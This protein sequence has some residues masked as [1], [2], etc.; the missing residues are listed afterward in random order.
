[1]KVRAF[2]GRPVATDPLSQ[3]CISQI[4]EWIREC[5][6]FHSD[7]PKAQKCRLPSRVLD[8]QKN[9]LTGDLKL[10]INMTSS[11]DNWIALS[12]CWAQ[13]EHRF[14][15]TTSNEGGLAERIPSSLLPSTI[16]DAVLVTRKTGIQYLGVDTLCILQD[17]T[18]NWAKEAAQ[19]GEYYRNSVFTLVAR[20]A[21]S[22]VEGFLTNGDV[23]EDLSSTVEV[24]FYSKT[25]GQAGCVYLR[26][27]Q[28]RCRDADNA[29]V[30]MHRPAWTL[31]EILL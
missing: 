8:V 21:A 10:S 7:C 11:Y 26:S 22:D 2:G 25:T 20:D 13:G 28:S 27:A 3:A 6:R 23:S 14:V 31:R 12:H 4:H 15:S 17:S 19:M 5:S 24:P 16:R 9:D 30:H 1:M 18:D 29:S